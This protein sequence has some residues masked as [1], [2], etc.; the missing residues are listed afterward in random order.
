MA[1][2]ETIRMARRVGPRR[3]T[4]RATILVLVIVCTLS[5]CQRRGD[6]LADVVGAAALCA[7]AVS[8]G[9]REAIE[10]AGWT[11]ADNGGPAGTARFSKGGLSMSLLDAGGGRCFVDGQVDSLGGLATVRDA[12]AVR[13]G[14][15]VQETRGTFRWTG[16][17]GLLVKLSQTYVKD[18]EVLR[19][20]VFRPN[21]GLAPGGMPATAP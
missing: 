14:P 21:V 16:P 4:G 18:R 1:A 2:G 5:G 11:L 20:F 10:E 15:A 13:L 3:P 17:G 12:L 9:G 7:G 8:G 19:L 6:P